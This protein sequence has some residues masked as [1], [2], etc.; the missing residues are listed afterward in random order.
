MRQKFLKKILLIK[1]R[2]NK[3]LLVIQKTKYVN[4]KFK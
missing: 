1:N 2:K 3:K 4:W